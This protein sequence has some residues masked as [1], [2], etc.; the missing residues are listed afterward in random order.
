[1]KNKFQIIHIRSGLFMSTGSFRAV[2]EEKVNRLSKEGNKI[3]S[4]S[5]AL[6]RFGFQSAYITIIKR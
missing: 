5:F 4:V 2:A 1:M 3:I 6:S